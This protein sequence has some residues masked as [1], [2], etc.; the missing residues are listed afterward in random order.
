MTRPVRGPI[1]SSRVSECYLGGQ[2]NRGGRCSL[3]FDAGWTNGDC[4]KQ[5]VQQDGV[6][7]NSDLGYICRGCG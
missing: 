5:L 1:L 3:D 4:G 7:T 2:R 6:Y